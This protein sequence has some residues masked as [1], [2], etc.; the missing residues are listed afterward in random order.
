MNQGAGPLFV[1][2]IWRSGTSLLYALLNQHPEIAL[3]YEGDL[4]EFWPMFLRPGR[5]SN[6]LE[7]WNFYSDAVIRHGID[8]ARIPRDLSDIREATEAVYKQYAARK[9]ATVW[10]CKSPSYYCSLPRLAHYFPNAR[11]IVIWR[12]LAGTLG[13]IVRAG[14]VTP[15]FRKPGILHRA[16][17]GYRRL[18]VDIEYLSAHGVRIHELNY[19]D[20]VRDPVRVM[21]GTCAFLGV[22]FD[23]RTASLAGAN[24]SAI[25]DGEHHSQVKSD[26]LI[27]AKRPDILPAKL[28][29]KIQRY[30]TLWHQ[31]SGGTWPADSQSPD[32]GAGKPSLL[33]RFLDQAL[34][35]ALRS[36]DRL[37]ILAFCFLPLPLLRAYRAGKQQWLARFP[38]PNKREA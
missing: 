15:W 10:G 36:F 2:G 24:R 7:R 4:P 20:L 26:S 1:V 5:K 21:K 16:L 22:P 38:Y 17:L 37:V 9:G 3:L 14:K 18:K 11:F 23:P 6:W 13:G 12:R 19:E 27:S 25:Y 35:C 30:L 8:P 33:E 28:D 32:A 34:F 31:Q 29:Q